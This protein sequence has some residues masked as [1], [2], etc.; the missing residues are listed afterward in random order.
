MFY[1]TESIKHV[2]IG[3]ANVEETAVLSK[4]CCSILFMHGKIQF[5]FSSAYKYIENKMHL[6]RFCFL[7]V[8]FMQIVIKG[9][10]KTNRECQ[11]SY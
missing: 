3:Y 4:M 11:T 6:E 9:K 2:N 5:V 7:L 1:N 10:L 8:V